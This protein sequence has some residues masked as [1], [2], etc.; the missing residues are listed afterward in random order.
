MGALGHG[1]DGQVMQG[2]HRGLQRSQ[3]LGQAAI[4]LYVDLV[5]RRFEGFRLQ[6]HVQG[7]AVAPELL[8]HVAHQGASTAHVHHLNASADPQARD[9]L[10]PTGLQKRP[11]ELVAQGH[12][13]T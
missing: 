7:G 3:D 2:V 5:H 1:G 4:G 9:V 11:F 12:R 10:I 13:L 6:V 8:A